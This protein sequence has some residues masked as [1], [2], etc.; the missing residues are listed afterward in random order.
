MY[1]T[2]IPT[3]HSQD[4]NPLPLGKNN[5]P[6][7]PSTPSRSIPIHTSSFSASKPMNPQKISTASRYPNNLRPS[8]HTT[9]LIRCRSPTPRMHRVS[10]GQLS[11]LARRCALF[12]RCRSLLPSLHHLS[13]LFRCLFFPFSPLNIAF[14]L[15]TF[16]S[17]VGLTRDTHTFHKGSMAE[18]GM[19][20]NI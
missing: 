16:C 5:Q 4:T 20:I 11:A 17:L 13:G 15:F 10:A 19:N 8:L 9:K 3:L 6:P 14:F 2:T 18:N 7:K 12:D 1:V